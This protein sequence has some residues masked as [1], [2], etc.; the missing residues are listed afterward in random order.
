[1]AQ[2]VF[3]LRLFNIINSRGL[4]CRTFPAIFFLC[5]NMTAW[6]IKCC[7]LRHMCG[8]IEIFYFYMQVIC[9]AALRHFGAEAVAFEVLKRGR[10]GRKQKSFSLF[11]VCNRRGGFLQI[12]KAPVKLIKAPACSAFALSP[13]H[14]VKVCLTMLKI[15]LF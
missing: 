1:M 13:T 5:L 9:L 14:R 7:S 11:C 6:D 8:P 15:S 12:S 10:G 4:D 2:A 3:R